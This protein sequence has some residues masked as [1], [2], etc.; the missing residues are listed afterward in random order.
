M[1]VR[2][3]VSYVSTLYRLTKLIMPHARRHDIFSLKSF[4]SLPVNPCKYKPNSSSLFH[5]PLALPP[6]ICFRS[7]YESPWACSLHTT[8]W[9]IGKKQWQYNKPIT[10][11]TIFSTFVFIQNPHMYYSKWI[12][13]TSSLL[14]N[15]AKC[16]YYLQFDL[17][18]FI[19]RFVHRI[20]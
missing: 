13:Q 6:L 20:L 5:K 12:L 14:Q 16:V 1:R 19:G 4:R 9:N 2:Y 7:P 15:N 18:P 10:K 11:S 3:E 17:Y 8:G